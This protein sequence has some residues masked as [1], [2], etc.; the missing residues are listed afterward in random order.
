MEVSAELLYPQ[1]GTMVPCKWEAWWAPQLVG[2][3]W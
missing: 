3:F 1:E 2:T